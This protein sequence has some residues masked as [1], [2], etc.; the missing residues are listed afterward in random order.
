MTPEG[1]WTQHGSD[2]ESTIHVFSVFR[3]YFRGGAMFHYKNYWTTT[4]SCRSSMGMPY[5]H[6]A[7]RTWKATTRC[8]LQPAQ[9]GGTKTASKLA[10]SRS[11]P[12]ANVIFYG[13]SCTDHPEGIGGGPLWPATLVAL[14]HPPPT[15]NPPGGQSEGGLWVGGGGGFGWVAFNGG[16]GGLAL[17]L[18]LRNVV[19]KL[20][21]GPPCRAQ[22][23]MGWYRRSWAAG[24]LCAREWCVKRVKRASIVNGLRVKVQ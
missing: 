20:C 10:R 13:V 3:N 24:V 23:R 9:L 5:I 12:H 6:A 17:C 7:P 8:L 1:P 11:H 22:R 16:G 15:Y 2:V 14:K 4:Y 18:G 21:R 19:S